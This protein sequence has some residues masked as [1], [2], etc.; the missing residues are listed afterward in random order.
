MSAPVL[1]QKTAQA[2]GTTVT[3]L[4]S[5]ALAIA[6]TAGNMLLAFH[7]VESF[8]TPD[9]PSGWT[10]GPTTPGG[11][12]A[13]VLSTFW[14]VALGGETT[15][16]VTTG[17]TT[18]NARLGLVEISGAD[19]VPFGPG[20]VVNH[21]SGGVTSLALGPTG[22]SSRDLLSFAFVGLNLGSGGVF[23]GT[24][25]YDF[26]LGYNAADVVGLGVSTLGSGTDGET[27]T[28]SWT[29][30][31][32]AAGLI[33]TVK[34]P[35]RTTLTGGRIVGSSSVYGEARYGVDTYASTTPLSKLGLKLLD[36]PDA[37]EGM[38][39]GP[40]ASG[41]LRFVVEVL[42]PT[43]G[44]GAKYGTAKYGTDVYASTT[45]DWQ[46]VTG[47]MRGIT[48]SQ[49]TTDPT[50]KANIGQAT[51][52]L[53]NLDGTYS[54]WVSPFVRAGL[55][56]RFGV[57][58]TPPLN[59]FLPALDPYE[60]F[61]TGRV[62]SVNETTTDN[63]DAQIN[64]VLVELTADLAPDMPTPTVLNDG[65]QLAASML[66]L[67]AASGWGNQN[68]MVVP[69]VNTATTMATTLDSG[70]PD[71]RIAGL[72]DNAHWDSFADGR[73]RLMVVVR[74]H[75]TSSGTFVAHVL[76][77]DFPGIAFSNDPTGPYELPVVT[78]APYSSVE[79]VVNDLRASRVGGATIGA[80]DTRSIRQFGT[81][82]QG[83][84]FPNT[85]LVLEDDEQVLS[86]LETVLTLRAW[87]DTGIDQ[88]ALNGDQDPV[89][90]PAVL[91]YLAA[92]AREGIS[93]TVRWVH[94]S[95]RVLNEVAVIEGQTHAIA[96][97]GS[98]L[99]WTAT[100]RLGHAG[101]VSG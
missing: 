56:V 7:L 69:V 23:T 46:D 60:A 8:V 52:T 91:A 2:S 17:A 11:A 88:I 33:L 83:Y 44:A 19:T 100:M 90:L 20:A 71:A 21:G 79:R 6:A 61:L 94:P 50:G 55:L 4:T 73:G 36:D 48:W 13:R 81:L 68:D 43:I 10:P 64:L 25:G 26:T 29:T 85:T 54:P 9:T 65:D 80:D 93:V 24:G 30:S 18:G 87:D 66:R 72:A 49:G 40:E 67:L 77:D 32:Q 45:G 14:K 5:N 75:S 84:G 1:V 70:S 42:N 99:L 89:R 82:G 3:T 39:V 62:D 53:A 101:V 97:E 95:G 28:V 59:D 98:Q 35:T 92:H 41:E 16:T 31:R 27:S 96:I 86:L 38:S 15:V 63:T 12:S 78:I 51:V 58:C 76:P 57:L 34:A 37:S 74:H 47:D 22:Q